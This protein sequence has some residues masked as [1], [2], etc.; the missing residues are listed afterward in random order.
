MSDGAPGG[1]RTDLQGL[2]IQMAPPYGFTLATF[3]AG[4]LMAYE[5]GAPHPLEI[6]LLLAG[7]FLG[8]ALLG[9]VTKSLRSLLV[10]QKVVMRGWQMLH[11]APLSTVFLLAWAS[12]VWVPAPFSWFIT[13][14]VLTMAYLGVLSA[15]IYWGVPAD[16]VRR[17]DLGG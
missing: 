10:P 4:G 1:F 14:I 3:T 7:A 2:L 5:H 12:A 9:M 8:Y 13:G 17:T 15:V 16:R 6:F 11:V